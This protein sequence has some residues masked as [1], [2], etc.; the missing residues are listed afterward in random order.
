MIKRIILLVLSVLLTVPTGFNIVTEGQVPRSSSLK[1]SNYQDYISLFYQKL[2]NEYPKPDYVVFSKAI[3]GFFTITAQNKI[4]NNLLTIIDFSL[5][6]N[7]KRM[8][9][10]D[11]N[12]MKV[13]DHN[14]VSHGQKSG[15]LYAESFSNTPSSHQSSLG[16]YLTGDIYYGKH[17]MSMYLEGLET[18]I[19][20]KARERAIVMHSADYVSTDFIKKNGRLGR[21]HGCPAIPQEGHQKT[22]SLLSGSS[23]LYIYHNDKDYHQKTNLLAQEKAIAGMLNFMKEACLNMPAYLSLP[24]VANQTLTVKRSL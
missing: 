20:D 10:V 13:I 16:F 12:E 17:G 9:I 14:L 5:S 15:A 24:F 23:C 19:N 1:S 18:G 4:K 7:K 21:S 8:W 2:G 22:I 11:V 3:T 6:S